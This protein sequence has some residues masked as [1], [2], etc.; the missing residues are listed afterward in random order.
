MVVMTPAEGNENA[1]Q[2][3]HLSKSHDTAGDRAP[4]DNGFRKAAP[5]AIDDE[6]IRG[7][8]KEEE[9][10]QTISKDAEDERAHLT[11][12][13]LALLVFCL[14]LI[15]FVVTLDNTIIGSPPCYQINRGEKRN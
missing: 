6:E 1:I 7:S 8:S 5:A 11:G 15:T 9:Q 13:P 14:C 2:L 12:V 4:P 3:Q 10:G